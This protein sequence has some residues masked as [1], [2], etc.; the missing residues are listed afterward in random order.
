MGVK[1]HFSGRREINI[2]W[3]WNEPRGYQFWSG[4]ILLGIINIVLETSVSNSLC[5]RIKRTPHVRNQCWYHL[6]PGCLIDLAMDI[7]DSNLY[8]Q[9]YQKGKSNALRWIILNNRSKLSIQ[10]AFLISWLCNSALSW[11]ETLSRFYTMT[12]YPE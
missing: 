12:N 7:N 2:N 9:W 11:W 5:T 10:L 1:I 3:F 8:R 4:L 6:S